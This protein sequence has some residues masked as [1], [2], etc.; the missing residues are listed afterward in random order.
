MERQTEIVEV[1]LKFGSDVYMQGGIYKALYK[2][3]RQ[4]VI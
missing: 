2:R 4:S 3:L 1:L